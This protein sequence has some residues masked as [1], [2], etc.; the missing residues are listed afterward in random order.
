MRL[1]GD[2]PGLVFEKQ[3]NTLTKR[4][5]V[6]IWPRTE[7]FR[8]RPVWLADFFSFCHREKLPVD[9]IS[10]HPYPTDW[11]LDAHG[12]TVKSTRGR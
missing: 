11:A 4:H 5:H 1:E 12:E 10:C 8:G 6:R 7:S 9:F 3:N 2:A